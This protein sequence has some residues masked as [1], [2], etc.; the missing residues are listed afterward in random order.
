MACYKIILRHR[1]TEFCRK[2]NLRINLTTLS[3][4][5]VPGYGFKEM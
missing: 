5:Q 1:K 4:N 2:V 3:V